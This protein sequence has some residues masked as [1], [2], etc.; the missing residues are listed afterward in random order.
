VGGETVELGLQ[1]PASIIRA[2]TD[3]ARA[4]C[5]AG[6]CWHVKSTLKCLAI[7]GILFAGFL[8][9]VD[10]QE[11]SHPT[12]KA[13]DSQHP[14]PPVFPVDTPEPRADGHDEQSGNKP[15]WIALPPKDVYDWIAYGA[16]LLLVV[17]GIAG[18]AVGVCTILFMR[19]QV[20]EM[21]RQRT[22]MA[23][24]LV[25]IRAQT[26]ATEEAVITA[27]KSLRLQEDTTKKQLR[28]YVEV[29]GARLFIR[30]DGSVEP[31]ITFIN[32]GQ[33]PA[34]D[35][36][37]AQ[38]GRFDRRPFEKAPPPEEKDMRPVSTGIVGGGQPYYFTGKSVE[39]GK[40]RELLLA[41]LESTSYAFIL[42]GWY[43]YRDIFEEPQHIEFQVRIGG[44]TPLQRDSDSTG[45]WLCFFNDAEGNEAT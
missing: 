23:R 22:L 27:N 35:L 5:Q 20:V 4:C 40:G 15:F 7:I 25:A 13:Q 19:A 17:V 24:T 37:G 45:E 29:K 30:D 21:T 2:M 26:K 1:H 33:T 9:H 12:P 34:H 8:V 28:A 11:T 41:D 6:D 18:I 32:C 36:H 44:G 39:S 10:A 3:T 16:N 38:Y 31:R 43:I 14:S 42:S